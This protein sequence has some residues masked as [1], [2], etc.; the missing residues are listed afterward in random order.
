MIAKGTKITQVLPSTGAIMS[1]GGGSLY[2][3]EYMTGDAGLQPISKTM[4]TSGKGY[5][6][7]AQGRFNHHG[8]IKDAGHYIINNVETIIGLDQT[9]YEKSPM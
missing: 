3:V 9:L 7:G 2:A 5:M 4:S 8:H 1:I 6:T